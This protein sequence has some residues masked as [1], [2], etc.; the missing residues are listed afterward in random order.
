MAAGNGVEV[1][2]G[3]NNKDTRAEPTSSLNVAN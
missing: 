1:I 3:I 2:T